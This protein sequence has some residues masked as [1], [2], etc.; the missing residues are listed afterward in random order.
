MNKVTCVKNNNYTTISNN[1]FRE[2]KLSLKAKGLLALVLTLPNDW[3]FTIDGI[4][5]IIKEG[6]T[7]IYSAIDE[8]KEH[9]YCK[10]EISRNTSGV[11]IGNDYT[12]FETPYIKNPHLEN[13]YTEN[14]NMDNQTQINKDIYNINNKQNKDINNNKEKE[15]KSSLKKCSK[16]FTPPTIQ[17]V[18]AF[19]KEKGY[20]F[21]ARSFIDYYEADNWH[22]GTGANRKKVSNWKRCC[23]TWG[24]KRTN[25]ND[26]FAQ[27]FDNNNEDNA[28]QKFLALSDSEQASVLRLDAYQYHMLSSKGKSEWIKNR[29]QFILQWAT[30]N[31]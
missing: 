28:M 23:I 18:E 29:K 19:I 11:F 22:Y 17:E 31:G 30:N 20:N 8:L 25:N 1:I 21:S 24:E 13:P 2:K 14:P 26:L 5:S 27:T 4:A 7:A 3:D 15:D 9:G 10:V 12:F 16:I 6:K